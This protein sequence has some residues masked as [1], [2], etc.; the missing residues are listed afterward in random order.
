MKYLTFSFLL[1]LFGQAMAQDNLLMTESV[2]SSIHGVVPSN[3]LL[4][5]KRDFM[6][7][8]KGS[9]LLAVNTYDSNFQR[10]YLINKDGETISSGYM[11][12]THFLPNA[13]FIVISGKS[14]NNK[15]SFNPYGAT[16][17]ASAIVFGTFNNFISRLKKNR[18]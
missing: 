17:V 7:Y 6:D 9:K 18:R 13:N 11:P 5:L 1:I 10:A 15:D 3:E 12:S 8:T 4:T 16:D 14:T 2:Y